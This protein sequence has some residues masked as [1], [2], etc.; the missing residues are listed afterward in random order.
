M[1]MGLGTSNLCLP[2]ITTKRCLLTLLQHYDYQL[3]LDY[4]QQNRAHLSPWEPQR[5]SEYFTEFSMRKRL[6]ASNDLFVHG[7]A[8][9]FVAFSINDAVESLQIIGVCNFTNIVRGPFQAC[10]LG[11][12]IA[13]RYQGQGLMREILEAAIDYMFEQRDLHRIMANYIP[14]NRRS[15]KLLSSL[16]F[17]KEGLAKD[18]LSIAGRWQDHILTSKLNPLIIP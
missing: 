14:E 13:E 2:K 17:E 10:N 15:G 11:Y 8:V 12:S 3:L 1:D 18:Y 4:Y 5:D 16:G 7:G 9:H 6:Q